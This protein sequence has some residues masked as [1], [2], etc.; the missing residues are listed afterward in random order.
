MGP[1]WLV[2]LRCGP[3][4]PLPLPSPPWPAHAEYLLDLL[5]AI[6]LRLQPQSTASSASSLA[7]FPA[8]TSTPLPPPP[9][10]LHL[11]TVMPLHL[12]PA[13]HR[14]SPSLELVT[15]LDPSSPHSPLA[16][17]PL[18]LLL[19]AILRPAHCLLLSSTP[20]QGAAD[21]DECAPSPSSLLFVCYLDGSDAVAV[22]PLLSFDAAVPSERASEVCMTKWSQS[23][24]SSQVLGGSVETEGQ[25]KDGADVSMRRRERKRRREQQRAAFLRPLIAISSRGEEGAGGP[26]TAES[27]SSIC[28][29]TP[30][31]P[32][33]S[34]PPFTQ[35]A[36]SPPPP[37]PPPPPG[38][39]SASAAAG[40]ASSSPAS[41]A[42]NNASLCAQLFSA[43]VA[44]LRQALPA[45][46]ALALSLC[47]T[48]MVRQEVGE[49]C[50]MQQQ[51]SAAELRGRIRP[52][53]STLI[54]SFW[55][56]QQQ[57]QQHTHSSSHT[58]AQQPA[59]SHS[60]TRRQPIESHG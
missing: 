22:E 51:L 6:P 55:Q 20:G 49:E 46:A 8:L 39:R 54:R 31:Q 21:V 26:V 29:S 1:S 4:Q 14:S 28:S 25:Q 53:A 59:T 38:V 47:V 13:R 3:L 16:P 33:P 37:P 11:L 44:R 15:A 2:R 60:R 23:D 52:V 7:S 5:A 48:A 27:S 56:Q 18:P 32:S 17:P 19:S 12:L 50:W 34:R 41:P 9:P 58:H 45:E 42:A 57:Q 40:L 24:S 30:A 35:S 36:P 43:A 10:F